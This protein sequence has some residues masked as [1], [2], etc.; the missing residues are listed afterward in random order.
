MNIF[1][2]FARELRSDRRHRRWR[3][4]RVVAGAV[5]GVAVVSLAS[6]DRWA[7]NVNVVGLI[8]MVPVAVMAPFLL[9]TIGLTLGTRLLATERREGTL[10]LLLLTH[11]TGRD[12]LFGKLLA[13]MV[14][15]LDALLGALPALMLPLMLLGC[16]WEELGLIALGCANL[17][18][19]AI[20]LGMFAAIFLD[21]NMAVSGCL[22][23]AL[24]LLISARPFGTLLPSGAVHE[25]LAALR[26]LNPGEPLAH[27]QTVTGGFRQ[28]A[29]WHPL[30]ASHLFA[31]GLLGVGGLLLPGGCRWQAGL[32]AQSHQR[33]R[34]L[35]RKGRNRSFASR[36]R[37]LNWNPFL[38]LASRSRWATVQVWLY[39]LISPL[40]WGWLTWLTWAR[41]G[42][43]VT[44]VFVAATAA[45]WLVTLLLTIPTEAGRKLL[46]DRASGALEMVLCTPQREEEIVR[47]Q[48]LALGRRYLAP[49]VLVTSLSLALMIAGYVTFGFGGMLDPEDRG[50]WVFVWVAALVLF[51]LTLTALCWVAMRRTLFARNAGEASGLAIIQV[52]GMPCMALTVASVVLHSLFGWNPEWPAQAGLTLSAYLACLAAFTWRSRMILLRDLRHAAAHR[53]SPPPSAP[54]VAPS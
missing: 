10:P 5:S 8:R 1:P 17:L 40:V 51:P 43:N 27:V 26:W 23:L 18:F 53:Y 54:S 49:L 25:W 13:A 48:W 30:L 32:N 22:L 33:K 46:E 4:E 38:W 45:S 7:G 6:A 29:Y 35:F 36:T 41:R 11:L 31:W 44:I 20:A 37:L 16:K 50:L 2:I 14:I 12:I 34:W 3:K 28:S 9:L 39:V 52:I 47:G 24:A 19:F 15:Q 42:I 21:E